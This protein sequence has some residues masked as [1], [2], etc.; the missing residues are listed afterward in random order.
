MDFLQ[1]RFLLAFVLALG[2]TLLATPAAIRLAKRFGVIDHPGDARR[3]HKKPTPRWGGLALYFG[4]VVAWLIVYPLSHHAPGQ[5]MVGPY[6]SNSLWI[7]GLSGLVV[8][9]GMLDDKYQFPAGLQ[10]VFLIAC[11]VLLSHPNFGNIRI[12]GVA[13]PFTDPRYAHHWIRFSELNSVLL[14]TLFVF[15][16]AKTMDTIDGVDGLAAGI[17]AIIATT[18]FVLAF[19]KQPLV[20]VLCAAA[21][22]SCLGFLRFNYHPAKIFMGTG[23]AQFLGFFLSALSIQGVVKTAAAVAF[24]VPLILFGLPLF[25]AFFVVLR[26]IASRSPITQA[27]KRHIHHT[28]LG[29]GLGQRQTVLVLYAVAILLCGAAILVVKVAA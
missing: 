17:A 2:A 27:D 13:V 15:I 28:L 3:V 14:T 18:M 12:E 26:R 22:G 20:G 7:I 25:D 1:S 5:G 9:F 10:A 6:T 11:G 19:G 8:L 23:G 24:V 29:R 21:V 4:V 16:V